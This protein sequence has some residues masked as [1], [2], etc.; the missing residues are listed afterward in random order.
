MGIV[1]GNTDDSLLEP[2]TLESVENPTEDSPRFI[3]VESWC[4]GQLDDE[5]R[6]FV[7]SFQ[8]TLSLEL[9]GATL[10]CFHGSPR[11]YHHL[12]TATTPDETLADFFSG[13]SATLMAGGHSHAQL[14]RRFRETTFVNPGS[15][16]LP[17]EHS[18]DGKRVRNP[19]W[20]EYALLTH[21][22]AR[23]NV[24]FKRAPYD[25]RPVLEAAL[26]SGMPHVDW[27][28]QGWR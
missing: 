15:V 23:L 2:R 24:E 28:V 11:S 1:L 19:P 9:D 14:L 13:Q 17:F 16:G 21:E 25:T 5:D 7:R 20:A 4:A 6:E 22:D 26:A 3:D 12:I 27:W 10:L 8:A 18:P